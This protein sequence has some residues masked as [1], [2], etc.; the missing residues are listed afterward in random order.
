MESEIWK[1]IDTKFF[2]EKAICFSMI[3]WAVEASDPMH[4]S[5]RRILFFIMLVL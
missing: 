2:G 5:A 3:F 1:F 4:S